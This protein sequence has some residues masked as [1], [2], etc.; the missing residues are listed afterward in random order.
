MVTFKQ[1]DSEI[2]IIIKDRF[3]LYEVSFQH[4]NLCFLFLCSKFKDLWVEY[5]N[6]FNGKR[7]VF[8]SHYIPY[9]EFYCNN[10]LAIEALTRLLILED[11]K[12]YCYNQINKRG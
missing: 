12:L 7:K 8:I 9:D 11:F 6:K 5:W 2:D 4:E 10:F 1:I 3:F